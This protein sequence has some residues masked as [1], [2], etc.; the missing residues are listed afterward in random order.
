MYKGQVCYQLHSLT[1]WSFICCAFLLIGTNWMNWSISFYMTVL[2]NGKIHPV[3]ALAVQLHFTDCT[4]LCDVSFCQSSSADLFPKQRAS[5]QRLGF[6]YQGF[7]LEGHCALIAVS[8]QSESH[9]FY[10]PV[11]KVSWDFSNTLVLSLILPFSIHRGLAFLPVS[12]NSILP[13][14]CCWTM[15][16][17]I[18]HIFA[19]LIWVL[20]LPR[21]SN[22]ASE[23]VLCA[24]AGRISHGAIYSRTSFSCAEHSFKLDFYG[25]SGFSF[26]RWVFINLFI[27]QCSTILDF[28][29][30]SYS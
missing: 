14:F 26:I 16:E 30:C 7:R 4:A 28:S 29:L 21:V 22:F 11:S 27:P 25:Y 17:L 13:S 1:F 8:S 5:L 24:G 19:H 12:F 20:L 15:F 10:E 2:S 3:L 18:A 6:K 9:N 23:I